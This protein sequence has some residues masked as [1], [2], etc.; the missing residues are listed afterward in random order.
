MAI[1]TSGN[2]M[3]ASG[4]PILIFGWLDENQGKGPRCCGSTEKQV[5]TVIVLD[6][7]PRIQEEH[8]FV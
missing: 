6:G 7:V 1:L 8:P 2:A 3:F 4:R 5:A